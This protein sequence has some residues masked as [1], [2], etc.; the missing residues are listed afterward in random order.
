MTTMALTDNHI[1]FSDL[2]ATTPIQHFDDFQA[3]RPAS[4]TGVLHTKDLLSEQ[5]LRFIILSCRDIKYR[6]IARKLDIS[7]RALTTLKKSLCEKLQVKGRAG[8][9]MYAVRRGMIEL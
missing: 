4:H 6:K 3:L 1:L 9:V 2:P 5:E 7:Y 8:L